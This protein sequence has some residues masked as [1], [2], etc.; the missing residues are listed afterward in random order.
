MKK[1]QQQELVENPIHFFISV[2]SV[3]VSVLERG[4]IA[5]HSSPSCIRS[6]SSNT[7]LAKQFNRG[8]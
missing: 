4:M 8:H 7:A 6:H 1:K 3:V 2:H 5:A